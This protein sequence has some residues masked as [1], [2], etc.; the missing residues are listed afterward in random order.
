[1]ITILTEPSFIFFYQLKKNIKHFIKKK[2]LGQYIPE[3]AGHYAVV[4]SLL[5]GFKKINQEYNY[6]PTKISNIS[7]HVHVLAG[8]NTLKSAIALKQKGKIKRLTAGPNIVILSD[9]ENGIVGAKEIDRY[10]VNSDWTISAYLLNNPKLIN[11]IDKWAAGINPKQWNIKK[12]KTDK[13]VAIFYKK[14]PEH[15]I[16]ESCKNKA[17][18]HGFEV[19]EIVCGSFTH[20]DFKNVLQKAAI[21]AYF[22]EQESQGIALQEIWATNTPTFVWNP[23]IWMYKNV[24]YACTSSPYLTNKTGDFFKTDKDFNIL[25]QTPLSQNYEPRKWVLENMTDEICA[26]NFIEKVTKLC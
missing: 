17:I 8:V 9:D 7:E 21:V 20:Q 24:N 10:F 16:Y 2:L 3:Y 26:K 12:I 5:D 1:M 4:R 23:G 25:I 22:V 15:Y 18:E 11:K 13:P 14:R 6:N 19:T